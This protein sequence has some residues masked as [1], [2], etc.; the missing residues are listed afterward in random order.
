VFDLQSP[1]YFFSIA[2]GGFFL[3]A[4][5]VVVECGS[6][7]SALLALACVGAAFGC[8]YWLQYTSPYYGRF[9]F[10]PVLGYCALYHLYNGLNR[11]F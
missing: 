7:R 10:V 2:G 9:L 11:A 4:L 5:W 6:K 8:M 3:G 1:R